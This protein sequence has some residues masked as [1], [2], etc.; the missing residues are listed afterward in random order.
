MALTYKAAD[1]IRIMIFKSFGVMKINEPVVASN[2]LRS[3]SAIVVTSG[4]G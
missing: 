2:R 1:E 3:N 4:L